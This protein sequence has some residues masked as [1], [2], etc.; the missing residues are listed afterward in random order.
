[1]TDLKF[2]CK[3]VILI[4]ENESFTNIK[5]IS[6]LYL[7]PNYFTKL[8]CVNT[9]QS[10][11]LLLDPHGMGTGIFC[12]HTWGVMINL[13]YSDIHGYKV[14]ERDKTIQN[15]HKQYKSC[16]APILSKMPFQ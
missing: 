16:T 4:A 6:N 10:D 12:G 5:F 3:I 2:E 7:I 9:R 11:W 14:I 13:V 8:W 15:G 1:M